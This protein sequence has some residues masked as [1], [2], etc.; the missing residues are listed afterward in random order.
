MP[1]PD[2]YS[3]GDLIVIPITIYSTAAAYNID[4]VP[5]DWT[6]GYDSGP[7][8]NGQYM[9]YVLLYKV[10]T[11]TS[12]AGFTLTNAGGQTGFYMSETLVYTGFSA[13][14]NGFSAHTGVPSSGFFAEPALTILGDNTRLISILMYLT[15]APAGGVPSGYT[16]R[17]NQN[18]D[19]LYTIAIL[20]KAGS[21]GAT[22]LGNWT[23]SGYY[24]SSYLVAALKFALVGTSAQGTPPST[25]TSLSAVE[26]PVY[27]DSNTFS[28][29]TTFSGSDSYYVDSVTIPTVS[30]LINAEFQSSAYGYWGPNDDDYG[31][32]PPGH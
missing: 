9:H 2:S 6:V 23:T 10:A 8:Y 24:G 5:G 16:Q 21:P 25:I 15:S 31:D 19:S 29:K 20:D 18:L 3:I 1:T 17:V 30:Q 12:E 14:D 26:Q 11:S 22:T 4:G 28:T 27:S 7:L 13:I 32:I